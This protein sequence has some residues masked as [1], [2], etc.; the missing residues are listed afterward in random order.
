[1]PPAANKRLWQPLQYGSP[2][3]SMRFSRAMFRWHP[4]AP[5]PPHRKHS[6]CQTRFAATTSSTLYTDFSQ[7]AHFG[8]ADP[9]TGATAD[10]LPAPTIDAADGTGAGGAAVAREAF[11]VLPEGSIVWPVVDCPN[12][13]GPNKCG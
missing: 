2:S 12:P 13:F 11:L 6:L 3:C 1:M 7:A 5:V 4:M 9:T 10:G 8:P